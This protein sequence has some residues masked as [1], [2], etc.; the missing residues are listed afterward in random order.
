MKK[1]FFL[2]LFAIASPVLA[3]SAPEQLIR[4]TSE[5]VI[6]EIKTNGDKY[7]SDPGSIHDLVADVVLPHFDFYEMTDLALGRHK[8]DVS[9]EQ[10]PVIVEEFRQRDV[11]QKLAAAIAT[12]ANTGRDYRL[13]E[14]CGGHTHAIFRFGLPRLLPSN[15][16]LVHGPG[17]PVCVTPLDTIDKALAI[18]ARDDVIFTSFG[19]MLRVPG[20]ETDLFGVKSRGGDVRIVYSPLDAVKIARENPDKEVVFFFHC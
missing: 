2:A 17:C 9:E 12:E 6:D 18:A 14:F 5:Q 16:E 19:D 11:A 4:E 13:M 20:S 15:I 7:R 3:A 1:W 8:D 10:K